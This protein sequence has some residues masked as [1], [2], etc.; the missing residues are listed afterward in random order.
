VTLR[1]EIL[2]PALAPDMTQ[3]TLSRWL[4]AEGD[5]VVA[6]EPLAEIE[7]DKSSVEMAATCDGR[8]EKILVPAGTE[9]VAIDTPIAVLSDTDMRTDGDTQTDA[10]AQTS[11]DTQDDTQ[12]ESPD[13][14][15]AAPAEIPPAREGR[16]FAS[17]LARRLAQEAGVD[18]K[19]IR[20]SGPRNR[21]VK[22]DI[23][24][25]SRRAE[26]AATAVPRSAPESIEL[27][28]NAGNDARTH[29]DRLGMRYTLRPNSTV[30]KT[31]ARRLSA[32]KQAVPHFYLKAE[33]RVDELLKLRERVNC[34]TNAFKVSVNDFVVYAAARA[35]ERVPAA[36]VT[37]GEE[38]ILQ[39]EQVDV[40]VAVSTDSGLITPVVR[41]ATARTLVS[42]AQEIKDLVRRARIGKLAP[43]E[44]NGG[45]F[46]VSNLGMYGVREFYA[47]INP[48]Q[49]CILAVGAA[50]PRPNVRDGALEVATLMDCTLSVDHRAVDG[51][52]AAQL[53]S[54]FK[55]LIEDPLSLLL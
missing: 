11:S 30:R 33:C 28:R 10:D 27:S 18:L 26:S 23:E 16:V 24:A 21:I 32:A 1:Q 2:L 25:A 48:P 9:A 6:G 35:L 51:A 46:C 17:P 22:A 12:L 34:R 3:G 54:T 15:V 14:A 42:V 55:R 19:L 7:T 39:Y 4:K 49:A 38:A 41:N 8:L 43:E 53:L 5:R 13:A 31:I 20:G 45:T 52:V 37:W 36:N 29:A 50:E 47:I 44:Y 40:S